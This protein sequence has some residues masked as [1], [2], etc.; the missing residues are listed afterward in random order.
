MKNFLLLAVLLCTTLALG[1][2]EKEKP[3]NQDKDRPTARDKSKG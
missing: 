3:V 2:G 1:C